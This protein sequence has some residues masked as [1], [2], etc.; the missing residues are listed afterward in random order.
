MTRSNLFAVSVLGLLPLLAATLVSCRKPFQG[1]RGGSA[2]ERPLSL[3]IETAESTGLP[4]FSKD[5]AGDSAPEEIQIFKTPYHHPYLARWKAGPTDTEDPEDFAWA[6]ATGLIVNAPPPQDPDA[7]EATVR[8][9]LESSLPGL[10][11]N[12]LSFKPARIPGS[13]VISANPSSGD[14]PDLGRSGALLKALPE[15]RSKLPGLQV[16]PNFMFFATRSKPPTSDPRIG[17]E[18]AL[19]YINAVRVWA[20]GYRKSSE[21]VAVVDMGTACNHPD[22]TD[23]IYR[24]PQGRVIGASFSKPGSKP[25]DKESHGTF[26]AGLIGAKGDNHK[27]ISG[28]NWEVPLMPVKFLDSRGCGDSKGAADA[29]DFAVGH[30]AMIISASW[31]GFGGSSM[32]MQNAIMSCG[33]FVTAAGNGHRNIDRK[34]FYP[35]S[36]PLPQILVAGA[37][38]KNNRGIF[39][40]G[41]ISVDL[42]APGTDILATDPPKGY[43]YDSGTSASAALVSG[44]A[45][46]LKSNSGLSYSEVKTRLITTTRPIAGLAGLSCSGGVLDL[47]RAFTANTT[48]Y[49]GNCPP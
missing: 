11:T 31:G 40:F 28:V 47:E 8:L 41:P 19:T 48:G 45:A 49:A 36:E 1:S 5:I 42:S 44:A 12:A 14:F 17:E 24:D 33:L 21:V 4:P 26:C 34:P 16:E 13:Y 9:A 43:R 32:L 27:G 23:N 7:V 39:N 6:V 38:Q 10:S 3:C 25:C 22:L 18:W 15:L 30:G 46:L 2:K 29:I 20:M 35:A 37:V